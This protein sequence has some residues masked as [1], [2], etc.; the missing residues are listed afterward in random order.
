MLDINISILNNLIMSIT[1]LQVYY[2]R[3]ATLLSPDQINEIKMKY[4]IRK[5]TYP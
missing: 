3:N 4:L 2:K 5:K 1:L